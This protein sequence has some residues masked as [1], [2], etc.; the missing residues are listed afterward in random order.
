MPT[1]NG[2]EIKPSAPFLFERT[3]MSDTCY[4]SVTC[5]RQDMARFLEL[6]F[7]SEYGESDAEPVIVLIDEEANFAHYDKL[8]TDIPFWG[9]N[10]AGGDYGAAEIV[11]DGKE[12]IEI[13][14]DHHG[15]FVV[16]WNF[17]LG[18]PKLKSILRIRRFLKVKHRVEQ[19]FKALE[20]AQP[21]PNRHLFSPHTHCC[22]KCGIHADDDAVENLPCTK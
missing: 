13:P 11:C 18:L 9:H 16:D 4:M 10:S 22:V 6:G 14:F 3:T 20:Q 21:E 12:T 15:G 2:V 5:R 17:R 19:I 7:H 1:L 8:P